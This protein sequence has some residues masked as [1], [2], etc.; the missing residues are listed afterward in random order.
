MQ[1]EVTFTRPSP[2]T[3]FG[4]E[5]NIQVAERKVF[6]A[7]VLLGSP[8]E[9]CYKGP[10]PMFVESINGQ[11]CTSPSDVTSQTNGRVEIRVVLKTPSA[12]ETLP[13]QHD[14]VNNTWTLKAASAGGGIFSLLGCFFFIVGLILLPALFFGIVLPTGDWVNAVHLATPTIFLIVGFTLTFMGTTEIRRVELK[15]TNMRINKSLMY[16]LEVYIGEEK[17]LLMSGGHFVIS[18]FK[19]KFEDFLRDRVKLSQGGKG[20]YGPGPSSEQTQRHSART[21]IQMHVIGGGQQP[22]D[23]AYGGGYGTAG[24]GQYG[25]AAYGNANALP[26]NHAWETTARDQPP[27]YK[28]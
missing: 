17:L 8:A 21:S 22:D 18:P 6:L 24:G 26:N 25:G 19:K 9:E 3:P 16:N 13:I 4:L 28:A 10:F 2:D 15:A 1:R 23:F 5:W 20:D 11:P 7:G 12:A 27:E 14:P